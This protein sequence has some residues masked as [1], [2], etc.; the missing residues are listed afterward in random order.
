M[1]G[2]LSHVLGYHS[3]NI[4]HGTHVPPNNEFEK[5][6]NFNLATNVILNRYK[7]VAV[8]TPWADKF[9]NYYQDA[10]PRII[11]GPL[12]YSRKD[13][14]LGIRKKEEI[15]GTGKSTKVIVYAATQKLRTGRRFH[16]TETPDEYISSLSDVVNAANGLDDTCFILRPHPA[17]D[18]SDGEFYTL[19]PHSDNLKII[20]RV[21]FSEILSIAD[22][23]ISYSSTCIEEAI[24]NHI[25]VLLFDKWGRYNHFNIKEVSSIG[26]LNKNTAYYLKNPNFLAETIK[27]ILQASGS[28]VD[29]LELD[30]YIY[31][32]EYRINF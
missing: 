11:S 20:S 31:P 23:L 29:D 17:S 30:E 22:L 6:E 2:E 14:T 1:I 10:R 8:Q 25:P 28:K 27:K 5:I 26:N 9:L 4:S 7:H 24:Q 3:L 13:A 16:I 18:I 15:L 12:L 19:L 21:P 32:E